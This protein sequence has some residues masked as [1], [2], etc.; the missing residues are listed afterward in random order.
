M[1]TEVKRRINKPT[2]D[3]PWSISCIS[4]IN[5]QNIEQYNE[6]IGDSPLL[7]N[8]SISESALNTISSIKTIKTMHSE[9][10]YESKSS[11]KKRKL[12]LRRKVCN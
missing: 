8:F 10:S 7:S 2:A 3:R 1:V 11:L 5:S 9:K 6:E 4:Q 12:K